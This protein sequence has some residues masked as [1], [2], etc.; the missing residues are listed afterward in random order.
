[1]EQDNMV[2][3]TTNVISKD[4][5]QCKNAY[6]KTTEAVKT[7]SVQTAFFN[8]WNF[9]L[10]GGEWVGERRWQQVCWAVPCSPGA[11]PSSAALLRRCSNALVSPLPGYRWAPIQPRS[12]WSNWGLVL[13]SSQK[14]GSPDKE[15]GGERQNARMY[16]HRHQAWK[17]RSGRAK[18]YSKTF[19]IYSK[20]MAGNPEHCRKTQTGP[21]AIFLV[22]WLMCWL[23][24]ETLIR[25]AWFY[26]LLGL[27]NKSK[28]QSSYFVQKKNP[29]R[30]QKV[31]QTAIQGTK[32]RWSKPHPFL[33]QNIQG[34]KFNFTW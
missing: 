13:S 6:L 19:S 30:F 20:L 22:Q 5:P 1:M 23:C 21:A 11:A 17:H 33:L 18:N 25:K 10:G 32:R 24:V 7:C 3:N 31:L 12:T 34:H 8:A 15:G 14:E 26:F 28:Y 2:L 4:K 16:T 29:Q 9:W 27:A